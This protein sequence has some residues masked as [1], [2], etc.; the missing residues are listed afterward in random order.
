MKLVHGISTV[1]LSLLLGI[2]VAAYAQEQHEQQ[3][4]KHGEEAK[5]AKRGEEAKPAKQ[6]EK[7]GQEAKPAKQDEKRGQ[8]AKPAQPEEKR[9]EEAKPA[10]RQDERR[11]GEA[12]PAPQEERRTEQPQRNEPPPR[13]EQPQHQQGGQQANH[14]QPRHAQQDK[15]AQAAWQ[16]HRARNW[17]S[18]HKSWRQRGGYKGYRIPEDR[19]RSSFGREHFFRISSVPFTV[20]DDSPRFQYGGFWFSLV[21]PWP[22]NWSDDWYDTDDCYV[23]YVDDGYYLFDDRY[24]GVAIAVVVSS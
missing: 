11:G 20:V 2:T 3:E 13:P 15:H 6:D 17:K 16:Q 18:D 24:P 10:A 21:D 23:D 22:E 12:K 4:E 19:F 1:A 14:E 7:R 9:G 5:P 8:E